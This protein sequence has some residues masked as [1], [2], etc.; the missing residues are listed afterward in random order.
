[1]RLTCE[2]QYTLEVKIGHRGLRHS[3]RRLPPA[4]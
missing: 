1:M 2:A 4:S 3:L